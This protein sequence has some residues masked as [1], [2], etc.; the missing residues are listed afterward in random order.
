MCLG[1]ATT[2]QISW[3][4][5]PEPIELLL[6]GMVKDPHAFLIFFLCADLLSTGYNRFWINMFTLF[7]GKKI[8]GCTCIRIALNVCLS[9]SSLSAFRPSA[10]LASSNLYSEWCTTYCFG[11]HL[12]LAD[13]LQVLF[14]GGK[15]YIGLDL[16]LL[17]CIFDDLITPQ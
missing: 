8:I 17:K 13:Q 14:P 7:L 15:S 12:G 3:Q 9:H 6:Y 11:A 5:L 1:R 4:S 2:V 16:F 10:S